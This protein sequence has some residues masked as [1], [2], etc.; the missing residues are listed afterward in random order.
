MPSADL[1]AERLPVTD[2]ESPAEDNLG[3]NIAASAEK[4]IIAT[5]IFF[6]VALLSFYGEF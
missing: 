4:A 3:A 2:D 5:S 6:M 1:I